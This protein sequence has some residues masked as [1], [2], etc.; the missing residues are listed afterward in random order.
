VLGAEGGRGKE[1]A[2]RGRTCS[3]ILRFPDG[4]RVTLTKLRT[5]EGQL[6]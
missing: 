4:P 3:F 2:E 1:M 5:E 6:G